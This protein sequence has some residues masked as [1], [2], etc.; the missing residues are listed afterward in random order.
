MINLNAYFSSGSSYSSKEF[1]IFYTIFIWILV[2]I[3]LTI[4][5]KVWRSK[6]ENESNKSNLITILIWLNIWLFGEVCLTNLQLFTDLTVIIFADIDN[7]FIPFG[8]S[9][10]IL[11]FSKYMQNQLTINK[12]SRRTST[13]SSQIISVTFYVTFTALLILLG[14]FLLLPFF[15]PEGKIEVDTITEVVTLILAVFVFILLILALYQLQNERKFIS[16]KVERY[17]VK[18]YEYFIISLLI[19][20][21]FIILNLLTGFITMPKI[22]NDLI[23]I[24]VY[25]GSTTGILSLYLAYSMPNWLQK[26]AGLLVSFGDL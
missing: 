17:R 5:I 14:R 3:N 11:Y 15:T 13:I 18:F 9:L 22:I 7:I 4:L 2:I 24:P 21:I 10:S 8:L 16:L 20:L 23:A 6:S 25:L 19:S 12:Y 26:R 1:L